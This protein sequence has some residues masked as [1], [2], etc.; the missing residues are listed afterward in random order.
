MA[1]PVPRISGPCIGDP[2]N[3]TSTLSPEPLKTKSPG[4]YPTVATKCHQDKA[5]NGEQITR[6]LQWTL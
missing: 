1:K 2:G 6:V 5:R 3:L 4:S